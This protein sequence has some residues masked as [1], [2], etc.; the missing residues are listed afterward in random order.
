M[1]L[2][3]EEKQKLH[4]S[5]PQQQNRIHWK[6]LEFCSAKRSYGNLPDG[7]A[8]FACPDISMLRRERFACR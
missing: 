2:R 6:N 1:V 8:V 7:M 3:A 5:P 4:A